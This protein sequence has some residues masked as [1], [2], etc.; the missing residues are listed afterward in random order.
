[1]HIK[2][3]NGQHKMPKPQ[4]NTQQGRKMMWN[5][6]HKKKI[7]KMHKVEKTCDRD[8]SVQVTGYMGYS[9][10]RVQG[11]WRTW[12]REQGVEDTEYRV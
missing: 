1:M 9:V 7:Q 4:T 8:Y 11:T 2:Y 5:V 10:H 12:Y 6:N 3:K